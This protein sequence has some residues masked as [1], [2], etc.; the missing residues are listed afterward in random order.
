MVRE[1]PRSKFT[2][3]G[4]IEVVATRRGPSR[5]VCSACWSEAPAPA[6]RPPTVSRVPRARAGRA[7]GCAWASRAL[8]VV[9]GVATR[10]PARSRASAA[11]PTSTERVDDPRR[12]APPRR[13]LLGREVVSRPQDPPTAPTVDGV[14]VGETAPTTARS[15]PGAG[16]RLTFKRGDP[17]SGSSSHAA[18]S[19]FPATCSPGSLVVTVVL[20]DAPRSACPRRPPARRRPRRRPKPGPG[21]RRPPGER[22]A[23]QGRAA[24]AASSSSRVPSPARHPARRRRRHHRPRA[25]LHARARR[26]LRQQRPRAALLVNGAWVGRDLRL[27]QRHLDRP[28]AHHGPTPRRS[29]TSSRSGRTVLELRR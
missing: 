29:A 17:V 25:E 1:S 19:G 5:P 22:R 28:P 23:D 9:D 18:P 11:A 4:G 12:L 3:V 21:P 26:R 20:P 27:H 13:I 24:R 14:Q 15:R 8:N 6:S 7:A 16:T 10:S 2:F